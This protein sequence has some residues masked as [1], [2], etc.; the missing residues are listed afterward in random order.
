MAEELQNRKRNVVTG[1]TWEKAFKGVD[2]TSQAFR[3]LVEEFTAWVSDYHE[4][5]S[6]QED[7]FADY[8]KSLDSI[9]N[10]WEDINSWVE[11][12]SDTL[13][14]YTGSL[15][16]IQSVLQSIVDEAGGFTRKTR[17]GINL[18]RQLNRIASDGISITQQEG[19]I[20][21]SALKSLDRRKTK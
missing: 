7:Q 14:T 15:T 1:E 4:F 8:I 19:G 13:R 17:D 2:K 12:N 9:Q 20:S 6:Y 16:D 21:E 10:H 11:K 5:T 18:F 3:D